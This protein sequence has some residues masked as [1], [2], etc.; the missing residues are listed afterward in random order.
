MPNALNYRVGPHPGCP[1]KC[2]MRRTTEKDPRQ[3][4][5]LSACTGGATEKDWLKGPSDH[6]L[7]EA[8]KKDSDRAITPVVEAVCVTALLALPGYPQAEQL[9]Y[10]HTQLS[11]GQSFHRQKNSCTYACWFASVVSYS[12]RP[13]GLWLARLLCQGV[14]FTKQEYWSVLANTGCHTLLE[15]SISCCP[16]C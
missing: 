7:Q 13:C 11:L 9:R 3:G 4:S 15:H 10:L 12:L 5:P 1:F 16:S 8:W 14:G 2:L 6:Q